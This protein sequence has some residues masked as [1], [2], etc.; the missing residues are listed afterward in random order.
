MP[1]GSSVEECAALV[2]EVVPPVMRTIRVEMRQAGSQ[3]LTVPQLRTLLFLA[4]RNGVSLSEVAEQIGLTMPSASRL[5]DLLVERGLVR[6][7]T[8][9]ADRRRVTLAA[10]PRGRTLMENVRVEAQARVARRLADLPP[11]SRAAVIRGLEAL[12]SL[13]PSVVPETRRR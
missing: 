6:R 4:R 1:S 3:E 5:V 2:M 12:Q 8:S 11:D 7:R 10:T 9:A 13:A